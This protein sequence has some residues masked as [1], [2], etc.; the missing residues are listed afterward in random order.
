MIYDR[1]YNRER[2]VKNANTHGKKK[3]CTVHLSLQRFYIFIPVQKQI[4][5]SFIVLRLA[6]GLIFIML[7]KSFFISMN[8]FLLEHMN[9]FWWKSL[10]LYTNTNEPIF[11]SRVLSIRNVYIIVLPPPKP[12]TKKVENVHFSSIN[13]VLWLL[14]VTMDVAKT[15]RSKLIL[16]YD[17]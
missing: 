13:F 12:P 9:T 2:F 14:Y 11:V 8:Q 3:T 16:F 10:F 6:V 17:C 1:E 7:K 5:P 4:F 15:L